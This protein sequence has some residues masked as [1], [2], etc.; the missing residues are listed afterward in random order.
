MS[1]G[2]RDKDRPS[3]RD[4]FRGKS[5]DQILEE[6]RK[7]LD[8]DKE[9]FF[10][11]VPNPP[12]FRRAGFPF[13]D[14]GLT[15]RG[16]PDFRHRLEELAQQ[17]PEFADSLRPWYEQQQ[18]QQP[19]Q[20]AAG[21][22][23]WGFR[24]R[25]GSNT[26]QPQ[27][28][29]QQQPEPKCEQQPAPQQQPGLAHHGLRN[30]VDLGEAKAQAEAQ[31]AMDGQDDRVKRAQS[32]PPAPEQAGQGGPQRFVSRLDINPQP[33]Q[34]AASQDPAAAKPPSG[35]KQQPPK[36][37]GSGAN[38]RQ[39][40]IFVEGRDEPVMAKDE[41]DSSA[42]NFGQGFPHHQGPSRSGFG[43]GFSRHN[44]GFPSWREQ[45]HEQDAPQQKRPFPQP[46]APPTRQQY[47]Q[48]PQQQHH[49]QQHHQQ[50]H[51]QPHPQPYPQQQQPPRQ[52]TPPQQPAPQHPPPPSK[53]KDP[54]E[55]VQE[56]R[57]EVESLSK[58]V[59]E[60]VGTQKDKRYI[61][62]D[63]ML[64]RELIKLDVIEAEGRDDVRL[65]RKETIKFIQQCISRLEAKAASPASPAEPMDVGPASSQ[66]DKTEAAVAAPEAV[67]E[68]MPTDSQPLPA[69]AAQAVEANAA[70]APSQPEPVPAA[71]APSTATDNADT[72]QPP[73]ASS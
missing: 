45:N 11:R 24:Q 30:T 4:R 62:L 69:D 44:M 27:A 63:E 15:S 70:P 46:Q 61:Y 71:P 54:L 60:F 58:D 43:Q 8:K 22:M 50:Q 16:R 40:P 23:G 7:K 31:A 68:A 33:S 32:A 55:K 36:A 10:E 66:S 9:M 13:D 6:L 41:V 5:G 72:T 34:P 12:S 47:Q 59:D 35:P 20:S 29:P 64:T 1:F 56:V 48:P 26:S 37:G 53:P 52:Q 49:Q 19:Q 67:P 3:L 18:Q 73:A 25:T 57:V 21:D 39:I 14:D 17:H 28:E 65:A 38:V 2:F 51:H 42:A